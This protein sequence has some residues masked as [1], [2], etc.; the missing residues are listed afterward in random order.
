MREQQYMLQ[1]QQHRLMQEMNSLT[2][3]FLQNQQ[4]LNARNEVSSQLQNGNNG[5][6]NGR[7]SDSNENH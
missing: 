5:G 2:F 7:S 6:L 1:M 4:L 3:T